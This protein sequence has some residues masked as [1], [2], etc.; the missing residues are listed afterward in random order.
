MPTDRVLKI[1]VAGDV[2]IDNYIWKRPSFS[3]KNLQNED[4]D[5]LFYDGLNMCQQPGGSILVSKILNNSTLNSEFISIVDQ[6]DETEKRMN[7]PDKIIHT[8]INLDLFPSFESDSKLVYRVKKFLGYT[9]PPQYNINEETK[10]PD[11][12]IIS[13]DSGDEDIVIIHDI[14]NGFRFDRKVWPKAICDD[15]KKPIIIY[16]M[17]PPLFRGL[18]WNQI[19]NKDNLILIL[20]AENLREMGINIS[21]SLSWE[22]TAF[23][24]WNEVNKNENLKAIKSLKNVIIRFGLEGA[25][26]YR[27]KDKKRIDEKVVSN[28]YFDP[29]SVEGGFW[30]TKKLGSMRGI[31]IV[32][33]S[34]FTFE[35]ISYFKNVDEKQISDSAF[36]RCIKFG[37]LKIREF[38]KIGH[39][40]KNEPVYYDQISKDLFNSGNIQN[41]NDLEL[42]ALPFH[43]N[44][45]PD[46]RWTILE[47]Q[48]NEKSLSLRKVAKD[49]VQ[50]GSQA[51]KYF[52]AGKFGDLI[53]V[54]RDEIE[55]FRSIMNVMNKYINSEKTSR[56]LSIAVFGDPGSGK[57]FGITQIAKSIDPDNVYKTC[58]NISQF[59]SPADLTTAFHGIRDISL[60]GKIPLVFFDEF[61]CKYRDQSFGWLRYFLVPMQD[62]EFMDCGGMHPIGKSIF[63]FAGGIYNSFDDFSKDIYKSPT[64]NKDNP[65]TEKRRDFI[66]RLRGYVNIL[67]LNEIGPQDTAFKIRRAIILRSLIEDKVPNIIKVKNN[68]NDKTVDINSDLLTALLEVNTYK[69]GVRS[70][71][72]IIDM[73]MLIGPKSWEKAYLPPKEQLELHVSADFFE[74]LSENEH[75]R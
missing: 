56:P 59:T 48:T 43:R 60:K 75:L 58:F 57:S 26:H 6:L 34:A 74:I 46:P 2:T 68:C 20:N 44:S 14:G 10:Y 5:W 45:K 16:Y 30:D 37:L 7:D 72:S 41:V 29:S 67:G 27:G 18:L 61:D 38:M 63:V 51:I 36:E 49:I 3:N 24:F 19:K 35:L 8:N 40:F 32:F 25:I 1:A 54:S 4:V 23:D 31:S 15:T 71:E 42:V 65:N 33:T 69:H 21:K 73:S 66:S 64:D 13:N 11:P 39:G 12:L 50:F 70:M 47:S 52:P 28:L 17:N 55:S 53:T 9:T 22:K 62:G